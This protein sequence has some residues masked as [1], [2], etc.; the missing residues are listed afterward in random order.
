MDIAGANLKSFETAAGMR[1]INGL[2]YAKHMVE[3]LPPRRPGYGRD[4]AS[5]RTP[6]DRERKAQARREAEALFAPKPTVTESRV[7]SSAELAGVL[8]A[9]P[10]SAQR[11][12]IE[13]SESS[14]NPE[15]SPA[16]AIPAIDVARIRTWLKYG[17]TIA[18]VAAVYG[19]D[20][21]EIARRLGRA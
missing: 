13:S 11:K 9:A 12:A 15:R 6:D 3:N 4:H 1:A 5:A 21:G 2:R 18:Q 16:R 10:A 19:V 7:A 14:I 17:M 8:S 20:A